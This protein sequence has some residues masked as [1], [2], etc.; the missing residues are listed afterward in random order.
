MATISLNSSSKIT[1]L[2]NALVRVRDAAQGELTDD[3][4]YSKGK[5]FENTIKFANSLLSALQHAH[6]H[7]QAPNLYLE[8]LEVEVVAKGLRLLQ[9]ISDD[10]VKSIILQS[11]TGCGLIDI[12]TLTHNIQ[13]AI[14]EAFTINEM[15]YELTNEALSDLAL[16]DWDNY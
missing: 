1:I 16:Y 4:P 11:Q 6:A 5:E 7:A 15:L 12:D 3:I 13:H 10:Q 9:T 14:N 8:P 2:I